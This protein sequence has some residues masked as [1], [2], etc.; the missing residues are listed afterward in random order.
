MRRI[1]AWC[2]GN[3]PVV[4]LFGVVLMALGVASIFRLNQE[5]LP[6]IDFPSV[7][8]VTQDPGASPAI[9]DRDVSVPISTALAGLP[10]AQHVFV[11]S[12]QSFSTVQ[13]QFSID[14]SVKDD[15]DAVNQRL[16]QVQLPDG[17]TKPNVQTFSFSAAP[18]MTYSLAAQDG[19]LARATTEARTVIAPALQ[20]ATGAAQIKV[21][22]G[23]QDAITITLDPVR[24]ALHH[25][26][27][28]QVSL[29]LTANQVD[30][31]AGQSGNGGT[32]VP[33]EVLSSLHS[34]A[35]LR[36]VPVGADQPSGAGKP[37]R[38]VTLGDVAQVA[39]APAPVNGIAR[40]DLLPSLSI[41]VIRDP[42]GNA[43]NLSN[44]IR[45]RVKALHLDPADRLSLIEDSATGIR[46]SLNDL[47]LEGLIGASLAILV[48]FLFLRSLRA[49][50]VTAVSLPTSV[51]VAL[52]GTAVGG[53]S[54]NVLTLAG[55]TIAVGRIIDDAI[56]VLENSY[57]H[58]QRGDPPKLA[59]LNG[60]T[61]VSK[62]VVSSTLTT[63]AVFLPIALVGGIISKFFVPFSVTVTISLLASL[64]VALTLIPVLV[65]FFLQRHAAPAESRR[66]W[67]LTA[68][69]PVL[70][71]ALRNRLSRA[72]VLVVAGLL[73]AGAV[74][75]VASPLVAKN[76]F[77]FGTTDQLQGQ[78][79][80]PPG[81]STQQT[82]TSLQA[83][84]TAAQR[85]AGVKLVQVTIAS[86]DFGGFTSSFVTN[87]AQLLVLVKDKRQAAAISTRLQKVLDDLYGVG[88]AQIGPASFG[89][90]SNRFEARAA[91]HDPEALRRA[92]DLIAAKLQQDSDLTN[93]QSDLSAQKPQLAVLVDP[94]KAAAHGTTPGQVAQIVRQ[95]LSPQPLG[96]LGGSGP[97]VTL[98]LDPSATT[99]DRLG[100]LPVAP[101]TTL[102][103][104]AAI[105]EQVAADSVTRRDGTQLVTVSA[106]IVGTDTS[107][108]SKRASQ[109]VAAVPLPAGVTLDTGGTS[110]D[111]N[112]SFQSM[113]EAIGIAIALVFIILVIFF[114][115]IVTPFVILVSM[116]LALIGGISALLIT[117][118]ALGLPALLGVLMVFG[119]VVS[120]AILLIDFTER[121][122]GTHSAHDALV[123]AGSTRLR[124]ILMTAVATVVALL[125]VALGISTSGGGGLISQSLA[126]VVEG[127]LISS[128][129]FT[130]VVVPVVYSLIVRRSGRL[131]ALT[132]REQLELDEQR[133]REARD[134]DVS[135]DRATATSR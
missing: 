88:N 110:E 46:A 22:G 27:P 11:Q 122:R 8:I 21:V 104:V 98:L 92:S 96:N 45:S 118:S 93:V 63:V 58:L 133:A 123:I 30:V 74:V 33:V 100:S 54:L 114:R 41:Q 81:T 73:F 67:M 134:L 59:A 75:T 86:S 71:W 78:V 113:F 95:A 29:A 94:A 49:T 126:V 60:A 35:D 56:V 61:E 108:I 64:L 40:T 84:E 112:A 9:V 51:L 101:G 120:N 91:G 5:L 13:V 23:E 85:D 109:L 135:D 65:S 55:L 18:S 38:V 130:L 57:R 107:G 3:R 14:S 10:H 16:S 119:I 26:A 53:F 31:P 131:R 2:L 19:N 103:D 70:G 129:V 44:D 102:R 90:T 97:P 68:Y 15:L 42:S 47:L 48:I 115:S 80:L 17:T 62:A 36:A 4:L 99:V 106:T 37:A 24:L 34:A 72:L 116:P 82:S 117:R 83:F 132:A 25:L 43:V 52:L 124:P 6:S 69:R 79:S 39:Q 20:G 111:I 28:A 50:L 105:S 89:P 77:D 127:G 7:F 1:V 121:A 76:F 66:S 125:P 12:S 128:T 32:V 87:Q